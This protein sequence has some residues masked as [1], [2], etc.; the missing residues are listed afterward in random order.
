MEFY[1]GKQ[2]DDNGDILESN[3]IRCFE[4]S[5]SSWDPTV[6]SKWNQS[7]SWDTNGTNGPPPKFGKTPAAE[8]RIT[9]ENQSF[10]KTNKD[11]FGNDFQ[12]FQ[13]FNQQGY[14]DAK[15]ITRMGNEWIPSGW[16][17]A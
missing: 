8:C 1:G 17:V 9:N 6:S 13:I 15:K 14:E 10:S 16:R 7:R 12:S 11:I 2:Q 5:K 4:V 3:E